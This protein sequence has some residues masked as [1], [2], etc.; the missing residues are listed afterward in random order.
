[1]GHTIVN[2]PGYSVDVTTDWIETLVIG[3]IVSDLGLKFLFFF[4]LMSN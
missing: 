3:C 2:G 4:L 1:M